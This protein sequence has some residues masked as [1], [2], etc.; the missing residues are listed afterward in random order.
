M[1]QE[2]CSRAAQ[3][4]K[5]GAPE[6]GSELLRPVIHGQQSN[7]TAVAAMAYCHEKAGALR[8]AIYLY[9]EAIR[10]NPQAP[11]WAERLAECNKK[12][13]DLIEQAKSRR[14]GLLFR[15][16]LALSARQ[17]YPDHVWKSI[18]NCHDTER[19]EWPRRPE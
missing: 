1:N 8:V 18:T 14:P 17:I 6:K 7:A 16:S 13:K 3:L 11:Q 9:S 12:H 19:I 5:Q 10:R 15:N 2:I 4:A